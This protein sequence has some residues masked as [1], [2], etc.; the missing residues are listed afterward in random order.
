MAE[1][2]VQVK[3]PKCLGSMRPVERSGIVIDICEDCRGVYLDRG[4]LERLI[5]GQ[6]KYFEEQ[7]PPSRDSDRRDD[8]FGGGSSSGHG[9]GQHGGKR[10]KGG[11]LGELFD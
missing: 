9:G 11:F 3:C 2:P 8:Y 4:E 1:A 5:D 6:A 7:R 10:R